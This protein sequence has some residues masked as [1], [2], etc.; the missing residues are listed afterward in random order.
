MTKAWTLTPNTATCL[1]LNTSPSYSCNWE[2]FFGRNLG[3]FSASFIS[4]DITEFWVFTIQRRQTVKCWLNPMTPATFSHHQF[5]CNM[6]ICA[7]VWTGICIFT[8]WST[9]PVY[10]SSVVLGGLCSLSVFFVDET[11]ASK[12][13][14]DDDVDAEEDDVSP[15]L[16]LYT[17]I[18]LVTM[19]M[20][21]M[22]LTPWHWRDKLN[23]QV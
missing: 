18:K 7:L 6:D 13:W 16:L 5:V 11:G 19:V 8:L 12:R 22:P 10:P 17:N 4:L 1:C 21:M 23:K 3:H 15:E 20:M 14:E 2:F 9:T